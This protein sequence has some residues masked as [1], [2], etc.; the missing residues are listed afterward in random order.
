MSEE[1]CRILLGMLAET[2]LIEV[3]PVR[4]ASVT[5]IK[6]W[7]LSYVLRYEAG[8]RCYDWGEIVADGLLGLTYYSDWTVQQVE[9]VLR[10]ERPLFRFGLILRWL[11]DDS[12]FIENDGL[13]TMMQTGIMLPRPQEHNFSEIFVSENQWGKSDLVPSRGDLEILRNEM[14]DLTDPADRMIVQFVMWGGVRSSV[15]KTVAEQIR[16]RQRVIHCANGETL[17]KAAYFWHRLRRE[18]LAEDGYSCSE[19]VPPE[20]GLPILQ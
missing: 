10:L 7:T 20:S 11:E 15:M 16:A 3:G 9:E 2:N 18:H 19:E 8:G 13:R 17:Q 12:R 14:M 4:R 5:R 1:K 6:R